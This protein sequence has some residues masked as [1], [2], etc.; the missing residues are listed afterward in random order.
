MDP[1][2]EEQKATLRKNLRIGKWRVQRVPVVTIFVRHAVGCKYAGDEFNKRCDCPKHLRWTYYRK[3]VRISAHS[4]SW[5]AAEDKKRQIEDQLAGRVPEVKPQ[6][7]QRGIRQAVETFLS[8]K[9]SENLTKSTLRKLRYQLG[10]FVDFTES[11][12][13]FF[14]AE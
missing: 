6:G 11:R 8:A 14:P 1:L 4:R 2:T 7:V 9:T 10:Q 12:S 13:K 5:A 3:Q